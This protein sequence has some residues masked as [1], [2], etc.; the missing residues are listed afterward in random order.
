VVLAARRNLSGPPYAHKMREP[1][2]SAA[3]DRFPNG[4]PLHGTGMNHS[5]A[6]TISMVLRKRWG[7]GELCVSATER[8]VFCHPD[9]LAREAPPKLACFPHP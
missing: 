3:V 6:I 7:G 5:V 1:C 9:A 8:V 4:V 2:R